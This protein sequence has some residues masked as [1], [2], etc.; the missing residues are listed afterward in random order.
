MPLPPRLAPQVHALLSGVLEEA[1]G[2]VVFDA[3][4]TLWRGDVGEDWLRALAAERRLP[5]ATGREY[6]QYEALLARSPPLAYAFG[7]QVLAG[8]EVEPTRAHAEAFFHARYRGRVFPWVRPV[9][10]ALHAR[11]HRVW[12][13]SASPRV[14]VEP[15]AAALGVVAA[16]VIGVE[17][18]LEAGRFT[19]ALQ[20]PVPCGPGKVHWLRT[21]GVEAPLL[22][23]GNGDLDLDM[24]A[25]AQRAL[26]VA[27]PD[28][29][30]TLLTREAVRRSWPILIC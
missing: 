4:G 2:D 24:L 6:A 20:A 30:P 9:L 13:C 14:I 19:A 15:G 27:P 23:A 18:A 22:A 29:R 26:V 21:R 10:E 8:L 17:V 16:R 25:S 5:T 7:A 3:D 1:P 12:V 11:G 28:A